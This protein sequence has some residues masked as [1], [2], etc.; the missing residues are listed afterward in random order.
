MDRTQAIAELGLTVESVF[1]PFSQSRNKDETR[2]S[3]NWRVTVKRNGRDV[4]TT[5]YSAG[6]AHCHAKASKAPSGWRAPDRYRPDGSFYPGTSS[7]YRRATDAESLVDYLEKWRGAECES[8][9]AMEYDPLTG[10]A[11]F[12]PK[13][14]RDAQ[15]GN[16]RTIPIL[17]NPL[18]VLY[19]LAMDSSVL[20]HATFESWASEFGY[21]T[22]SRSAE[23]IY[24]ACLEIALKLRAAMGDSGM[25]RLT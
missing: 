23:S 14:V 3:L 7:S 11:C 9:L 21:D 1:V 18:D 25:D 17:P 22:D 19:S 16:S 2:K 15:A 12:K 4:L 10:E 20:D 24:R 8:G 6:V 13:R 5:D